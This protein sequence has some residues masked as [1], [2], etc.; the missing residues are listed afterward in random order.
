MG[1]QHGSVGSQQHLAQAVDTLV[2][3]HETSGIGHR[4]FL[5]PVVHAGLP[6]RLFGGT[7]AGHLRVGVDHA[8]DGTVAHRIGLTQYVADSHFGLAYGRVGQ[9]RHSVEVAA[10]VHAFDRRLHVLVDTQAAAFG[11]FE[12]QVLQSEPA[13]HRPTAHAHQ[14]PLGRD[15]A[16]PL[17]VLIRHTDALVG[18]R[19]GRHLRLQQEAHAPFGIGLLQHGGNLAVHRSQNLRQH[20][21]HRHLYAQAGEE[22]GELHADDAS[23]HDGQRCR[24]HLAV[25]CVA[26]GPIVHAVQPVN[27]RDEGLRARTEQQVLA[28]VHL[29]AATYVVLVLDA[30]LSRDDGHPGSRQFGL[31]AQHQFA[32]H[33]GFAGDDLGQVD[34]RI[35][36]LDGIFGR[37]ACIVV[38][39]GRVEQRLGGD[40]TLVQAHAAQTLF[41]E[42]HHTQAGLA[43]HLCGSVARRTTADNCNLIVHHAM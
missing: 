14:Q 7:H 1:T 4:Q 15:L 16:S 20:L 32:H 9:Q 27:G 3:G 41:F 33:F 18:L 8:G 39:L 5:H 25:E 30:G 2:L 21:H 11:L 19:H 43:R 6:Q 37:M 22:R 38:H 28:L 34:R 31:D 42:K 17:F 12:R 23:A 29:V 24:Q 13:R 35:G 36:H 10:H 40:A 26:V